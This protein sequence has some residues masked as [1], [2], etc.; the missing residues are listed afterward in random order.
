MFKRLIWWGGTYFRVTLG[1]IKK[2]NIAIGNSC[3]IAG[4]S[5][6]SAG[7]DICIGDR[8]YI[9]RNAALS[10]HLN[11]GD[12]VLIASNV[13]FV[14]GDHRIDYI[15]TP[16]SQSGRDEIKLITVKSNVWIGHGAIIMHGVTINAGSVVAAGSVVTKDVPENGIVGG[17]PAKLIRFR[18]F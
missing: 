14:G 11:I 18:K 15:A 1:R 3:Y 8:T 2:A 4:G 9:G 17:N 13:S 12:D 6:F 16:M 10:C 7:R 5:F